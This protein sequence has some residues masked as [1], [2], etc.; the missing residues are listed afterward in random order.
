M[1][2][3]F[4]RVCMLKHHLKVTSLGYCKILIQ[5]SLFESLNRQSN[6][7]AEES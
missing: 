7:S 3:G 4:A 6:W 5:R 2:F 1:D